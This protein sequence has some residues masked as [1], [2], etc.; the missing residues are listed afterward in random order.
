MKNRKLTLKFCKGCTKE[1]GDLIIRET[2]SLYTLMKNN[3]EVVPRHHPVH[4]LGWYSLKPVMGFNEPF[5]KATFFTV[6]SLVTQEIM[7][8]EQR[9]KLRKLAEQRRKALK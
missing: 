8:V 7:A 9:R 1:C 5:P 4:G 6:P 3:P 2:G